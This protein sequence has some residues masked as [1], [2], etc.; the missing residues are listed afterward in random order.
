MKNVIIIGP[1]RAGKSTLANLLA[2]KYHYQIIRG[3]TL[4][5]AF[6]LVFPEL[7][8]SSTTAI[9]HELFKKFLYEFMNLNATYPRNNY[10]YVLESCD[11]T[12]EDYQKYFQNDNTTLCVL[13]LAEITPKELLHHIRYYD[14]PNDWSTN[15]TDNYMLEKCIEYISYS[16]ENKLFCQDHHLNYFETSTTNREVIFNNILKQ[17]EKDIFVN[18]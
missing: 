10:P 18:S 3:D 1:P 7:N 8:I 6:Y 11:I 17:L 4:R 2:S 14:G 12:I 9:H 15:R 5:K 13:G 16:K